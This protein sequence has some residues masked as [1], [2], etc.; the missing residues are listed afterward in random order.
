MKKFFV[1]HV[2]SKLVCDSRQ[3]FEGDVVFILREKDESFLKLCFVVSLRHLGYHYVQ[4]IAIVNKNNSLL[5]L[6]VPTSLRIVIK[7]LD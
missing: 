2:F 3:V 6:I 5:I 4:E 1:C 7:I